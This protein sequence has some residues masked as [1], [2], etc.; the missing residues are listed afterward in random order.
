M[1]RNNDNYLCYDKNKLLHNTENVT[2][3]MIIWKLDDS[4]SLKLMLITALSN[5]MI[6]VNLALFLT[7]N[8]YIFLPW[9]LVTVMQLTYCF[10]F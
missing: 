10:S 5:L 8:K 9:Q 6:I 4:H 2:Y 1:H 3:D 7:A